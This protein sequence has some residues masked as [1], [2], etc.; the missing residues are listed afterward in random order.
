MKRNNTNKK[1]KKMTCASKEEI[2]RMEEVKK[3]KLC[4]FF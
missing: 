3:E 4:G 2:E 1:A